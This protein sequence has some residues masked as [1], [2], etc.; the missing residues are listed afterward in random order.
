MTYPVTTGDTL[1]VLG[2]FGIHLDYTVR[3]KLRLL[4]GVDANILKAAVEKTQRRYP[5][6]CVRLR[7]SEESFFYEDNPAPVAVLHTDK[8]ISLNT[9]QTHFH[10]WCVCYY[11]DCLYLDFYHGIVDGTGMYMVLSTLLYYYCAERYGVTDHTGIRTLD[12]PILP[13]ETI[14]PADH[15]PTLDLSGRQ[16]P[17][18][19]PAFSLTKDGGLTPGAP[20]IWDI[21]IPE[22]AFVSFSSAN[23][24]SPGTMVSI[25]FARAIDALFPER[26]SS[27]THRYIVNAR[28][29]LHAE[30][31]HHNCLGGVVFPYTDRVKAMPFDRQCTVHRGATF[32]QSDADRV[33]GQLMGMASYY[34]MTLQRLPTVD[35]KKQAFGKMMRGG[36]NLYTFIVSYVGQWKLDVLSPYILEFWTHVPAANPL[37]TEIAAINGKIFLSVHHSIREDLVIKSFLKQLEDNDIPYRLRQPVETDNAHFPEPEQVCQIPQSP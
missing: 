11:G 21:E 27:I 30:M 25:L 20:R 18:P 24:A 14:D 1:H 34:R 6:L 13:E 35:A 10:V 28:P 31:T 36:E 33:R 17:P 26:R 15:L 3:F 7:K 4:N 23:D 12:D 16:A 29:M 5:Y 19:E 8:R 37:L 9:E 22:A 2:S 32:I